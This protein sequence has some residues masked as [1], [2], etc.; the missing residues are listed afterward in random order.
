MFKVGSFLNDQRFFRS[1]DFQRKRPYYLEHRGKRIHAS[2]P[3]ASLMLLVRTLFH[4]V[5]V[6]V[7]LVFLEDFPRV[8]QN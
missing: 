5:E 4:M 6:V 3:G 7:F 8:S 1:R 2:T